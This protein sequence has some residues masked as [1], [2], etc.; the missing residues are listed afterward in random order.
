[1]M[2]KNES[3]RISDA[4]ESLLVLRDCDF[5]LIVIDDH[6]L[7]DT[8]GIV[9]S[10]AERD[11]RVK[12]FRNKFH[13]KVEGTNYGF[14]LSSGELV[15]CIDADDVLQS[16][17]FELVKNLK[18]SESHCHAASVV[19]NGL[20]FLGTYSVNHSLL[21]SDFHNVVSNLISL[22]KWSWTFGRDVAEKVFPIPRDMP[23][24]DLW[25]SIRAKQF[26]S[27]IV[28]DDDSVYLYRQHAGQDYGGILNYDYAKVRLRAERS[29]A[30][31]S[32]LESMDEYRCIDFSYLKE[33]LAAVVLRV[34]ILDLAGS[35]FKLL[36]K[37][38]IILILHFPRLAA[39]ATRVKWRVDNLLAKRV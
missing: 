30:A 36:D 28:C 25:M 29:L 14:S 26:S 15:K 39:L 35:P 8:F 34:S 9:K 13:G 23:I 27:A 16:G 7:D 38:K 20:G 6:S 22:P 5:E 3:L 21:I 10:Y 4:I 24:E 1:M 18:A 37:V 32:I 11:A 17:Y 31:I 19:D 2:A 33:Y 12:V